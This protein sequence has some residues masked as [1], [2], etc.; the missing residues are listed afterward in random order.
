MECDFVL[1]IGMNILGHF[2]RGTEFEAGQD[3]R[4][5]GSGIYSICTTNYSVHPCRDKSNVDSYFSV[6]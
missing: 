3:Q 6:R 4:A 5:L 1:V 2:L